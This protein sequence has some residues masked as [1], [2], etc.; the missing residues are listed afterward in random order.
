MRG[1]SLF[2]LLLALTTDNKML[3]REVGGG[4]DFKGGCQIKL[5]YC[6]KFIPVFLTIGYNQRAN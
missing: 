4:G 2:H 1:G 6:I 5:W 3:D